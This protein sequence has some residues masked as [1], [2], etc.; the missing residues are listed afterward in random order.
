MA[1]IRFTADF[2]YRPSWGTVAYKA[3]MVQNVTRDCATEAVGA[4]K[5]IRLKAPRKGEVPHEEP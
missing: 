3:G 5:A 4:G 2:D 1:W